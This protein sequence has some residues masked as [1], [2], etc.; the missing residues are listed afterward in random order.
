VIYHNVKTH[1]SEIP[2][3]TINDYFLSLKD[4]IGENICIK[5]EDN[6][7]RIK[8]AISNVDI[9]FIKNEINQV[10]KRCPYKFDIKFQYNTYD[11]GIPYNKYKV[12]KNIF[13]P[14]FEKEYYHKMAIN[15]INENMKRIEKLLEQ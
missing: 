1:L 14:F 2:F 12:K 9:N 6:C 15:Q 13:T 3:D 4:V 10:Q 11:I 8:I 7:Y 5:V